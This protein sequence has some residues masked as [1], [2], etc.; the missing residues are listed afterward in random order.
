M[1]LAPDAGHLLTGHSHIFAGMDVRTLLEDR[2][3]KR[4][5]HPFVIW[6]PFDAEGATYSYA[7][8][9]TEARRFAA[10]LA[11][12]R[13]KPGDF[14]L[15]HLDNCPEILIGWYGCALLG[16]VAVTTN[17]RS[18]GPELSYFA[19]NCGARLAVTQPSY[20]ALVKENCPGLEVIAVT[21]HD[22]G[23]PEPL[24]EGFAAFADLLGAAEDCPVRPADPM[25]PVGVQY[26]SGTTSRP[27][28]VVWTHA[29]ALWGAKICAVQEGLTADDVHLA[30]LPLF[31]TNAQSYSVLASLWAGGTVVIQPRFSASRFWDVSVKHGCTFVSMIPFCNKALVD[32]PVPAEHSYRRMGNGVANFPTDPLFGVTTIGWWGMTETITHGIVSEPG[33]DTPFMHIGRASAYY[34]IVVED[35]DGTPVLPGESGALK[36]GGVRGLSLFLEYLNNEEATRAA[37]DESGLFITGDRVVV[38]EGGSIQF[39][40][41][42]KDMLKVGGENVAA[43]EIEAVLLAALPG[44]EVAVVAKPDAMLDEVPV[45]FILPARPTEPGSPGEAALIETAEA[46]CRTQLADFKVPRGFVVVDTLPRATLNKIAKAEL[47]KRV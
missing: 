23:T 5:E 16:A 47:R 3:V 33:D 46:A 32:K 37:F 30:H 36:V 8:F 4:A 21:T 20:A 25:A 44:S 40:D 35:E 38:H 19:E 12:R 34:E 28:G 15:L 13:V 17:T 22:A 43:S 14:V 39:A 26:T 27:K 7:D 41:R 45:A 31:H 6:E 10:G 42:D 11:A 24:P 18:A 29:N 1:V 2:A 9:L